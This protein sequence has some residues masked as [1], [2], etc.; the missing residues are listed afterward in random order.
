MPN[1]NFVCALCCLIVGR[2]KKLSFSLSFHFVW[3]KMDVGEKKRALTGTGKGLFI[4]FC[5]L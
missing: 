1:F 5:F 3:E 4:L 2:G